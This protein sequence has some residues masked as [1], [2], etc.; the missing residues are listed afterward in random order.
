M[1]PMGDV[2]RTSI[3]QGRVY[4]DS[5]RTCS[6]PPPATSSLKTSST[7]PSAELRCIIQGSHKDPSY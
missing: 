3:L 7:N 6:G 2:L 1:Y 4:K 5:V